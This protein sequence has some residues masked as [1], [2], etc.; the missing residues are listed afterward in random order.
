MKIR[1][2]GAR[3]KRDVPDTPVRRQWR[4]M[5]DEIRREI[6]S[7][8]VSEETMDVLDV[9][10]SF[11]RETGRIRLG[12]EL[13]RAC[14]SLRASGVATSSEAPP[15]RW[16]PPILEE[17]HRCRACGRPVYRVYGGLVCTLG[18]GGAE[19]PG[20]PTTSDEG[21]SFYGWDEEESR[22]LDVPRPWEG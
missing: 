3:P 9:F 15:E 13:A 14:E 7:G 10:V 11:C 5:L 16:A 12:D 20:Q 4:I 18:H 1:I 6:E 22:P 21:E 17:G 8:Q 2:G 19:E